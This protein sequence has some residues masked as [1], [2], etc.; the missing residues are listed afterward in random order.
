M[1]NCCCFLHNSYNVV[2][3]IV[4]KEPEPPGWA[5]LP[6][7]PRC[8]CA[9]QG[10]LVL[11]A[12]TRAQAH[13]NH[14]DYIIAV[15]RAPNPSAGAP[16]LPAGAPAWARPPSAPALTR[17]R[18]NSG[19]VLGQNCFKLFIYLWTAASDPAGSCASDGADGQLWLQLQQVGFS[20]SLSLTE[21]L[22]A[23]R[24]CVPSEGAGAHE[25]LI[26]NFQLVDQAAVLMPVK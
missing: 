4:H 23:G 13:H 1:Y 17:R 9:Q 15:R 25:Q 12:S 5:R 20:T 22:V 21:L 8:A 18:R 26:Y 11:Y 6:S 24:S 3:N 7:L 14:A 16:A 2:H 19:G 10:L